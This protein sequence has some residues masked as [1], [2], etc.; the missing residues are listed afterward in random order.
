ML[1]SASF[2]GRDDV[3]VDAKANGGRLAWVRRSEPLYVSHQSYRQRRSKGG[4]ELAICGLRHVRN[5]LPGWLGVP[6]SFEKRPTTA[7]VKIDKVALR[8]DLQQ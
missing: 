6:C 2:D 3:S 7:L 1:R 4:T 5:S 8:R